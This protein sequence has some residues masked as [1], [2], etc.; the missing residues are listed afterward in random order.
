MNKTKLINVDFDDI[1]SMY[2]ATQLETNFMQSLSVLFAAGEA[3]FSRAVIKAANESWLKDLAKEFAQQEFYHSRYHER[4]NDAVKYD[5]DIINALD[6]SLDKTL[7]QLSKLL[8]NQINLSATVILEEV[9]ASLGGLLL[10]D[11]YV[12]QRF[13]DDNIRDLWLAHA[14]DE[15]SHKYVAELIQRNAYGA[16]TSK[17]LNDILRPIVKFILVAVVARNNILLGWV[18]DV[19]IGELPK[20]LILIA[21]FLKYL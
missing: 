12:Q 14:T 13:A 19:K 16:Y 18:S 21:K 2:M 11:V 17:V 20:L 9:T 15:V 3:Y 7:K 10:T 6:K 1:E 8:P 5:T 4:L